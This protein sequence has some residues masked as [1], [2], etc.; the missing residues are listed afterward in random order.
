LALLVSLIKKKGNEMVI[1]VQRNN[2]E[3]NLLRSVVN[4]KPMVF[5]NE[6]KARVLGKEEEKQQMKRELDEWKSSQVESQKPNNTT[7][8]SNIKQL[9]EVDVD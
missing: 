8:M 5:P 9:S 3:E 1:P 6:E 7:T 2:Q 4:E